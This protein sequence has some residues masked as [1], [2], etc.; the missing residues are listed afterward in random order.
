[1]LLHAALFVAI[2]ILGLVASLWN[3]PE[4]PY[5]FS[6]VAVPDMIMENETR[7]QPEPPQRISYDTFVQE[8]GK[9]TRPP[10]P[11]PVKKPVTVP[12][13][14]V[15]QLVENLSRLLID[16]PEQLPAKSLSN[17]DRQA[18]SRYIAVLKNTLNRA[19]DKPEGLG[20]QPLEAK[21]RFIVE[22][23]GSIT[24]LS[25]ARSSDNVLFD[26]SVLA[27]FARVS[28]VGPTPGR[29]AYTL[30]LTFR[31]VD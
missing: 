1:M 5:I 14:V 15:G 11:E 16:D 18:L 9:P 23:D 17:A 4:E 29:A 30:S 22:P 2:L 25:L 20:G 21:A 31:M 8:Y 6:L 3:K 27:A 28:G 13:I 7:L 24:A 19:W 10:L 26:N 12:K